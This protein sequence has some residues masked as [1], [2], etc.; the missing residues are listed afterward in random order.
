MP[1]FAE[2][3]LTATGRPASC[4][5]YLNFSFPALQALN[6]IPSEFFSSLGTSS[7]QF[8]RSLKCEGEFKQ[9]SARLPVLVTI[10]LCPDISP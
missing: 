2:E 5:R 10:A 3:H 6:S 1:G 8:S 4:W 9:L 7:T